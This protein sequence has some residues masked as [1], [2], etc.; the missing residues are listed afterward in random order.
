[1]RDSKGAELPVSLGVL[2][3][4]RGAFKWSSHSRGDRTNL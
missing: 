1:V 4:Y 3:P 2:E